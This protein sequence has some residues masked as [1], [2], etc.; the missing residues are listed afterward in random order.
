MVF[1]V[2]V[3]HL[4]TNAADGTTTPVEQLRRL[5]LGVAFAVLLFTIFMP[6]VPFDL[7]FS[8]A[9]GCSVGYYLFNTQ[10]RESELNWAC[11]VREAQRLRYRSAFNRVD[12]RRDLAV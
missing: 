11:F 8:S 12:T 7:G 1:K 6:I 3:C 10:R 4:F 5:L 9:F 2:C